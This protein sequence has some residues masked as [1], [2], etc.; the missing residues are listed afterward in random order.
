LP[1]Q[2]NQ[3]LLQPGQVQQANHY[4]F[5]PYLI[6]KADTEFGERGI[7]KFLIES[8]PGRSHCQTQ[9]SRPT[10]PNHKH[11]L[12][13]LVDYSV[14]RNCPSSFE[15]FLAVVQF[16]PLTTTGAIAIVLTTCPPSPFWLHPESRATSRIFSRSA[17]FAKVPSSVWQ[18]GPVS[19]MLTVHSELPVEGVQ[20]P[21]SAS[22]SNTSTGV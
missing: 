14:Q 11:L 7:M 5:H 15:R 21:A 12:I 16:H 8:N 10:V 9:S 13:H 18:T 19:N 20:G 4:K 22:R 6:A 3:P 2:L 17:N 1:V